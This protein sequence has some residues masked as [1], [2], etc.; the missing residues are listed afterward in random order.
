M[1]KVRYVMPDSDGR[2]EIR[3]EDDEGESLAIIPYGG[4]RRLGFVVAERLAHAIVARCS[5][6]AVGGA[7]SSRQ[8]S[9]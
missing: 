2:G 3:V 5:D 4:D 6:V 1:W 9:L 7:T 8:P